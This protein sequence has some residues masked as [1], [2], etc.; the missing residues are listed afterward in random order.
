MRSYTRRTARNTGFT[1]MELVVVMTIIAILAGAVM[2]QVNKNIRHAKRATALADIKTIETAIGIYEAHNGFPPSQQ[3][4]LMALI[5]MPTG[6]PQPKNWQGPYLKKKSVPKDPW[7]YE[8]V[9]K[10]NG[11]DDYE[12]MS[13]GGDG[14]PGGTGDAEDVTSEEAQ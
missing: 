10:L 12:V 3:Q 5:A 2:I 14:Q 11:E 8:Y 6:D 13:T 9:Y 7:G 4:G 1:L